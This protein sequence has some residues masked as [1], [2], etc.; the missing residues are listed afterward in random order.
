VILFTNYARLTPSAVRYGG[1]DS[2]RFTSLRLPDLPCL[3]SLNSRRSD[4]Q[5]LRPSWIS[6]KYVQTATRAIWNMRCVAPGACHLIQG[7]S[8]FRPHCGVADLS[9]GGITIRTSCHRPSG[10][11]ATLAAAALPNNGAA[12]PIPPLHNLREK[13]P[14]TLRHQFIFT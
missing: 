11:R 13:K 8:T 2:E 10:S 5:S 3:L 9:C 6:R 1:N 12:A 7:F 4:D 14:R